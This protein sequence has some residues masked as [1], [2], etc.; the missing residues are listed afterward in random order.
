[1]TQSKSLKSHVYW[2]HWPAFA[3]FY[4]LLCCHV[5]GYSHE[6]AVVHLFMMKCLLGVFCG[7]VDWASCLACVNVACSFLSET[8]KVFLNICD[9]LIRWIKMIKLIKRIWFGMY[10]MMNSSWDM[11]STYR[12]TDR[13][14]DRERDV[15]DVALRLFIQSKRKPGPHNHWLNS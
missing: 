4:I 9:S 7:F 10:Y 13:Q 8:V 3:G 6:W 1:M 5:M 12:Q 11:C 15:G 14:T 2:S